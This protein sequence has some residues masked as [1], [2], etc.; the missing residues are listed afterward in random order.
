MKNKIL[1]KVVY[2]LNTIYSVFWPNELKNHLGVN[3]V[4]VEEISHI[5]IILN[6]KMIGKL[7]ISLCKLSFPGLEV[8][9]HSNYCNL[10]LCKQENVND[11]AYIKQSY[12]MS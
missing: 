9:V 3:P 2:T 4:D 10:N 5:E 12:S 11:L 6:E 7:T 8:L 1:M